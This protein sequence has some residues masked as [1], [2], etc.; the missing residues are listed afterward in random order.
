[1]WSNII[2]KLGRTLNPEIAHLVATFYCN[3]SVSTIMLGKEDF[4]TVRIGDSKEHEQMRLLLNNPSKLYSQF[5]QSLGI[6]VG[7]YLYIYL[8]TPKSVF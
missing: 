5:K 8:A 2:T 7:L 6:K 3:D 1:M 4:V